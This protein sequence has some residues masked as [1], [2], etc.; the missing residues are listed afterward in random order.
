ML[1]II[2]QGM[3]VLSTMDTHLLATEQ[4][5][6][7]LVPVKSWRIPLCAKHEMNTNKSYSLDLRFLKFW[8]KTSKFLA[9]SFL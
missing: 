3:V 1:S 8:R 9:R 5:M 7:E 2:I 4:W 6:A